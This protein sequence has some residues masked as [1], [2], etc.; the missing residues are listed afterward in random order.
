MTQS[1]RI[2]VHNLAP[3]YINQLPEDKET[4]FPLLRNNKSSFVEPIKLVQNVHM[5][6]QYDIITDQKIP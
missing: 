3:T 6:K 2:K 1:N 5:P 4:F